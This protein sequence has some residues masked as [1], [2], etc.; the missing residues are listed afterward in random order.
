MPFIGSRERRG[1]RE[2]R[3]EGGRGRGEEG[4]A[5]GGEGGGEGGGGGEE[6]ALFGL[7]FGSVEE[8]GLL[9]E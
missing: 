8:K 6:A 9:R 1:G 3:E 7:L 5:G 4:G 2:S